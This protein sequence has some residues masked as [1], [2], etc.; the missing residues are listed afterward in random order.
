MT[1][2]V[3]PYSAHKIEPGSR[4][5]GHTRRYTKTYLQVAFSHAQNGTRW[6]ALNQCSHRIGL[7]PVRGGRGGRQRKRGKNER[8]R[9]Y[10]AVAPWTAVGGT[11]VRRPQR[12][13]C[14]P[15]LFVTGRVVLRSFCNQLF[16]LWFAGVLLFVT[17]ATYSKMSTLLAHGTLPKQQ[18]SGFIM[19]Y[20][21]DKC[22]VHKYLVICC[23]HLMSVPAFCC[24]KLM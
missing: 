3:Q 18:L 24:F 17:M 16:L 19:K 5:V 13:A 21:S 10:K 9:Y 23:H 8:E 7:N 15:V 22:Q 12:Y 14:G 4:M 20:L 11:I 6:E 2:D 1:P